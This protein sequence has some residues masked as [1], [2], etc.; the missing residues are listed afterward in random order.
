MRSFS[1]ISFLV[2]SVGMAPLSDTETA[3]VK[4]WLQASRGNRSLNEHVVNALV[5]YLKPRGVTLRELPTSPSSGSSK[6]T[7]DWVDEWR[8]MARSA[9]LTDI[10][11]SSSS[12]RHRMMHLN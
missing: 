5:A 2:A 11:D 10:V 9:G 12:E 4:G 7:E 8:D 3:A 1:S 6:D